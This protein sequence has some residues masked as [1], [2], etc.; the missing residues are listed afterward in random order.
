MVGVLVSTM[1]T[2]LL[3]SIVCSSALF[4][5]AFIMTP[6]AIDSDGLT[7]IGKIVVPGIRYCETVVNDL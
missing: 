6:L 4:M 7:L 1:S 2:F 5:G 3:I